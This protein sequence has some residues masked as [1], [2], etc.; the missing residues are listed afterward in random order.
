M[1][2][3]LSALLC[4]ARCFVIVCVVLHVMVSTL[5]HIVLS[6]LPCP[7]LPCPALPCS[8]LLLPACAVLLSFSCSAA[9][10]DL[11]RLEYA[12]IVCDYVRVYRGPI[13]LCANTS[14]KRLLR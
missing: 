6:A 14:S 7:A 5:Q 8:A 2:S 13:C 10:P 9:Q 11:K 1:K 4:S 12:L 3:I